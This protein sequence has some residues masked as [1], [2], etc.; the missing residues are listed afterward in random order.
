MI[1]FF[2]MVGMIIYVYNGKEF[3]F[4]EIKEEMIG[5]YFGEFVM[6]RKVV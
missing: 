1:V 6:M 4:V 2:E 3:V 5:Y